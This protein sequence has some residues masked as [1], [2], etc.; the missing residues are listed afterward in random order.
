MMKEL[1]SCVKMTK[2]EL[3]AA[4]KKSKEGSC[5]KGDIKFFGETGHWYIS[6]A[7]NNNTSPSTPGMWKSVHI[8]G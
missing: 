4:I 3:D 1:D 2:A 5:N 8:E 7:D 6:Q